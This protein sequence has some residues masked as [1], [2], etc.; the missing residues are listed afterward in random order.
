MPRMS[1]R[2]RILERRAKFIGTALAL[3]TGCSR[4]PAASIKSPDGDGKSVS[5]AVA[6]DKAPPVPPPTER[7]SLVA[8]VS[9]AGV[10]ARDDTVA[11]IKALEDAT[12]KL[13]ASVPAPCPLDHAACKA[14]LRAFADEWA[15]LQGDAVQLERRCPAKTPDDRAVETLMREHR[16]WLLVWLAAI[17]KAA[18]ASVQ[19]GGAEWDELVQKAEEAHPQPCLKYYCP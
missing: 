18:R 12:S 4:D 2:D 9:D 1:A 13:A 10:G 5:T 6:G 17:Q 16:G 8:D 15:R 3:A 14:R 19:G 11:Q 7:P